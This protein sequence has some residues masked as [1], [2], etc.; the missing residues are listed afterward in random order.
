MFRTH[1]P[2]PQSGFHRRRRPLFFGTGGGTCGHSR[3]WT[4]LPRMSVSCYNSTVRREFKRGNVPPEAEKKGER[5]GKCPCFFP[6]TMYNNPQQTLYPVFFKKTI[7]IPPRTRRH[8]LLS[9]LPHP[10][11]RKD[12]PPPV[13]LLHIP[14]RRAW[15]GSSPKSSWTIRRTRRRAW[16]GFW[17]W[18]A[19]S[20]RPCCGAI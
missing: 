2:K 3:T 13:Q 14:R 11:L 8:A 9:R 20:W 6:K 17:W 19:S 15:R 7:P 16:A 5:T 10:R 1:Q 12:P 4:P 18:R